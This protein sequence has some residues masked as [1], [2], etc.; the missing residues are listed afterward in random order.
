M[1][2]EK[3]PNDMLYKMSHLKKHLKDDVE[4]AVFRDNG[5]GDD[6]ESESSYTIIINGNGQVSYG[7]MSKDCFQLLLKDGYLEYNTLQT[8]KDRGYHKYI[9]PVDIGYCGWKYAPAN[10]QQLPQPDTSCRLSKC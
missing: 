2:Y 8:Y 1:Q 3:E 6:P 7:D 5:W 10:I 4:I 9:G